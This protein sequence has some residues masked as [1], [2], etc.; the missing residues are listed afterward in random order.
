MSENT[1]SPCTAAKTSTL[2]RHRS[3]TAA[4]QVTEELRSMKA[5]DIMK[6]RVKTIGSKS[7]VHSAMKTLVDRR[8]TGLPVVK[9]KTLIGIITE[10]DILNQLVRTGCQSSLVGDHMTTRV[11]TFDKEDSVGD[12][13]DCLMQKHFRRVPI[14]HDGRIVGIISRADLIRVHMQTLGVSP[15]GQVAYEVAEGPTARD[16]M[17]SGLLITMPHAS[18]LEAM[19]SIVAHEVTGLPVVDDGLNLVGM[20]SEKDLLTLLHDPHVRSRQVRDIMSYDLT[21]AGLNTG[22]SDICECLANSGFRRLPIV[23]RGRLVGIISR[24]D[25]IKFIVK[26]PSVITACT[27]AGVGSSA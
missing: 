23:E 18:V 20:V 1:H 13:F 2:A 17:T 7:T 3:D 12:I 22:L 14:L 5:G 8:V 11:T 6:V 26:T 15:S 16:I 24:S 21:A 9:A 4:L 10:K 27:P 25:L 19:S